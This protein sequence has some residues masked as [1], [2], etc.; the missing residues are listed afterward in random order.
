MY[1][2]ILCRY[3][4]ISRKKEKRS[5]L[6]YDTTKTAAAVSVLL[7]RLLLLLL[8]I[9]ATSRETSDAVRC[10][11]YARHRT[12]GP[13]RRLLCMIYLRKRVLLTCIYIYIC[14]NTYRPGHPL[15]HGQCIYLY[16]KKFL[17][18]RGNGSVKT[19]PK[20]ALNII[21]PGRR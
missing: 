14:T 13:R 17:H 21:M 11:R 2:N 12:A 9:C 16:R 8:C 10:V 18:K 15:S 4:K 1:I 20:N 19:K 5:S 6:A 3:E 7:L